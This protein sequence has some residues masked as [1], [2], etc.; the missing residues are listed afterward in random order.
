MI[1]LETKLGRFV[2]I[3][4][5]CE[6]KNLKLLIEAQNCFVDT[7]NID[8]LVSLLQ[9]LEARFTP[10]DFIAARERAYNEFLYNFDEKTKKMLDGNKDA[11]QCQKEYMAVAKKI[12]QALYMLA[13]RNSTASTYLLG[14]SKFFSGQIY[15]FNNEIRK[16]L[17]VVFPLSPTVKLNGNDPVFIL[18]VYG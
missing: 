7:F 6:G 10:A 18:F 1:E 8:C 15:M 3:L 13:L 5:Q 14:F 17:R 4:T 12:Y 16:I 2:D 11:S 9:S